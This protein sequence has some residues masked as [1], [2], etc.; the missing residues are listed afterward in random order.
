MQNHLNLRKFFRNYFNDFSYSLK[1]VSDIREFYL[2]KEK[3]SIY[4]HIAYRVEIDEEVELRIFYLN[5]NNRDINDYLSYTFREED[6]PKILD[7]KK[8]DIYVSHPLEGG[9]VYQMTLNEL[10]T[11]I[12]RFFRR[13]VDSAYSVNRN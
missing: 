7:N 6:I 11:D 10:Y 3:K 2:V 1:Q 4:T 13:E 9:E 8:I 12:K 5:K